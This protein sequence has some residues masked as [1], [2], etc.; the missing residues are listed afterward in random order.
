MRKSWGYARQ[1]SNLWPLAPEASALSTEL[2][3]R[4]V[5]RNHRAVAP[6]QIVY[7]ALAK[8]FNFPPESE[9]PTARSTMF[10][11]LAR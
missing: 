10:V 3:A 8:G 11:A 7:H 4:G 6:Q 9:I 2:R 5:G 1:D